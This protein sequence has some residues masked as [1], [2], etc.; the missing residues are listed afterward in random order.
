MLPALKEERNLREDVLIFFQVLREDPAFTGELSTCEGER[1]V[2][3]RDNSIYELKNQGVI[4]PKTEEDISRVLRL[5]AEPRFAALSVTPKGGGT[6]TNGQCLGRG[7]I[8]DTSKY[9][10]RI[11][12]WDPHKE[13]V[14]VQSGTVL[15][16]PQPPPVPASP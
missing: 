8:L 12:H 11:L 5:L 9:M 3:S 16:R 6:S 10:N 7:L 4:Y 13:E 15:A 1:L 14:R 2:H